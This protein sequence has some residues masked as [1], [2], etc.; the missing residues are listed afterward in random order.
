ML[1]TDPV[2]VDVWGTYITTPVVSDAMA[3]VNITTTINNSFRDDKIVSLVNQI[4]DPDGEIIEEEQSEIDLSGNSSVDVKQVLN[5]K[6]PQFWDVNNPFLYTVKTIIKIGKQVRD[7][8]K[9]TLGVR[10]IEFT[11]DDGFLLNGRRLQLKGVNLHHD[12]G[13]LGAKFYKRAME[14]QLEIM[15]QM[16]CNA[17]R[18]SHNTAAP[19]LLSACDSMGILVFNEIFD[20]WDQK[21]GYLKGNDFMEFGERNIRNFIKRGTRLLWYDFPYCRTS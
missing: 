7:V 2:H 10:T 11:A 17:V 5:I 9:S 16:G 3:E 20:K 19:E 14:R 21:A 8:Y 12:H 18:T 4:F 13:P 15:Q 1:I 6:N